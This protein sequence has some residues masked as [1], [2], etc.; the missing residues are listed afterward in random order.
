MMRSPISRISFEMPVPAFEWW[1]PASTAYLTLLS[2]WTGSNSG[3]RTRGDAP[4]LRRSSEAAL[5]DLKSSSA[6]H[7][8]HHSIGVPRTSRH[9]GRKCRIDVC[10]IG[11]RE[12]NVQAPQVFVE[13]LNPA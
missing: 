1:L 8:L 2:S 3:S 11:L 7:Q 6:A 10:E 13:I 12:D 4:R 5:I 9:V